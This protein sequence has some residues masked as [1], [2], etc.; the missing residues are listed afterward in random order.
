MFAVSSSITH[1]RRCRNYRQTPNIDTPL[2]PS[3]AFFAIPEASLRL[4][5]SVRSKT[6]LV[7]EPDVK[8][9]QNMHSSLNRENQ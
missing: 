8:E 1:L 7:P 5:N 2:S 9:N 4:L 6:G 3:K